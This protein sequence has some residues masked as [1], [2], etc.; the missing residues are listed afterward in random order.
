MYTSRKPV[1]ESYPKFVA[2]MIPIGIR[3]TTGFA[4][5]PA[6]P[7]MDINAITKNTSTFTFKFCLEASFPNAAWIAPVF[8]RI[9]TAPPT[10]MIMTINFAAL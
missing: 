9:S 8:S 3:A 4:K 5:T 10:N 7:P 6:A 1:K 2:R